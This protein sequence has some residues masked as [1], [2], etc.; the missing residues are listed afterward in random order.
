MRTI[1]VGI[2]GLGWMG[3]LHAKTID[4]MG[5]ARLVAVCDSDA[6]AVEHLA[7][8]YGARGHS[9]YRALLAEDAVEAVIIALPP[10]LNLEVV[11]EAVRSDKHVLCEKPIAHDLRDAYAIR[12]LV[13]GYGR[14]VMIGFTE[15]FSIANEDAQRIVRSGALGRV[16]FVRA[17]CRWASKEKTFGTGGGHGTW[18]TDPAKGG[19]I[20][21]AVGIHYYDLV[22]WYTGA[23]FVEV[24]VEAHRPPG[25]PPGTEEMM[26]LVGHLDSG[27]IVLFDLVTTLPKRAPSDRRLE[28]VGTTGSIYVDQL[29]HFLMAVSEHGVEVTPGLFETGLALPESMYLS[30]AFGSVRRE[31]EYFIGNCVLDGAEPHPSVDAGVRA[32]EV[33][34]GVVESY[35]TGMPVAL[36]PAAM[37]AAGPR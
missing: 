34:V 3:K 15:R 21:T 13:A 26:T 33:A 8:R 22:R 7:E 20:L 18:F 6:R 4:L 10:Y 28:V 24:Y 29:Q 1:G 2:I 5:E 9:D 27:A 12:D 36:D 14:K 32:L 25:A 16:S 37:P 35:R 31:L 23:E 11:R 17:N 30:E 19:G